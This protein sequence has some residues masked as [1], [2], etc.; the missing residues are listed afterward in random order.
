MP[1]QAKEKA[2]ATAKGSMERVKKAFDDV[3]QGIRLVIAE[4]NSEARDALLVSLGKKCS[5]Y[6]SLKQ[7]HDETWNSDGTPKVK[8]EPAA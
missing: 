3:A 8:E 2:T 5:R 6:G 1:A 4:T 7:F